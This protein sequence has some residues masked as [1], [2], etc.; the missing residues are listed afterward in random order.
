MSD[1]SVL[2]VCVRDVR[3][4]EVSEVKRSEAKRSE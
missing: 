4:S 1:V 3:V 2:C